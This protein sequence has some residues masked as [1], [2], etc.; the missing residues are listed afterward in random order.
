MTYGTLYGV[1]V[2]PGAA[3]LL[4]LR[5]VGV[6]KS[7][8]AIAI[9]RRSPED[10]SVAWRI[11]EV[12][13][14]A[15]EGQERFF[16]TLPMTKDPARMAAAW[17]EAFTEIGSR[18]QRG[19]SVAFVTEGDPLFFSTFIYLREEAPRR[20]PGIRVEIVPGVSSLAAVAAATGQAIA[21]GR[22]RVA[23]IPASYGLD[24]LPDILK[25]FDTVVL[26]KVSSV[27]P[28]IVAAVEQA[29]LIDRAVYVAQA[30]RPQEKV[31]SDIRT[32]RDD[33]GDYFSMVVIARKERSGVLLGK[34][35]QETT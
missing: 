2:G 17:E 21:D 3:D 11:A 25:R 6:L 19:C 30:S 16:V 31:V 29:G 32:I 7:A 26:M 28:Q 22:E 4:T 24:D 34:G 27:M 35:P 12:A 14:G 33:R 15:V 9:P 5:A 8:D 23:I 20:W 10:A 1:G 18:L 13:V